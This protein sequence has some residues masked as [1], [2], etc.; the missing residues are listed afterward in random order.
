VVLQSATIPDGTPT[1]GNIVRLTIPLQITVEAGDFRTAGDI[2]V[3]T[4]A[5]KTLPGPEKIEISPDYS[6]REGYDATFLGNG[7]R[8]IP[9][10][11]LSP[12]MVAKVALNSKASGNNRLILP[13]HHYSVIMNGE[14]GIAY[15]SAVNIDGQKS[16]RLKREPDHWIPDPRIQAGA[17]TGEALY[18]NNDFDRGH[19]TRRLDPA[20]GSDQRTAKRANDDTFHF[21]NCSP[22]HKDFN[23]GKALWA[24]LEDYILDHADTE[25]FKASVFNGPV[26]RTDDPIYR[27]VQIPRQFW[28]VVAM[29]KTDGTLSATAYVVSQENLIQDLAEEA[30]VFGAYR[31]FQ[32]PVTK[33]EELT[34]LSFHQLSSADPLHSSGTEVKESLGIRRGQA[35]SSYE[36]IV[37]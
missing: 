26:F 8:T 10:P 25:G 28:K 23:Q 24:G 7:S 31:T 12:A 1:P 2:V 17:Q 13:Y 5:T 32:V 11:H 16:I 35:V 21:T 29:I 15:V 14:R 22:Q 20:W 6:D 3:T 37:L 9:M 30:F 33:I 18:A 4:A 36:D 19:L 27:G 34:G